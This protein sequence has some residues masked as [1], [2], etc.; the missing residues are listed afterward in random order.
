M[1]VTGGFR[2]FYQGD[3]RSHRVRWPAE[4]T[5]EQRHRAVRVV[6]SQATSAEDCSVLL[7]VLGLS[8]SER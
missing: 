4:N 1:T 8:A 2:K 7:D 3:E 5:P 6:A